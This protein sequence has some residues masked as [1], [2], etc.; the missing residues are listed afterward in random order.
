MA[1]NKRHFKMYARYDGTGK[2]IPGSNI[3]AKKAPKVG[4]WVEVQAYEC[5]NFTTTTTSTTGEPPCVTYQVFVS[6]GVALVIYT[7]CSGEI[8]SV[9]CFPGTTLFCALLGQYTVLGQAGVFLIAESCLV[10]TTTTTVEPVACSIPQE[11][12]SQEATYPTEIAIDLG[13]DVGEV[14]L[15]YDPIIVPDR[16]VVWWD[17][18]VVI[19]TGYVSTSTGMYNYG[20]TF[21]SSLTSALLGKVDPVTG[22]TYPFANPAHDVDN[23]PIVTQVT[24]GGAQNES[25]DKTDA[26]PTVALIRV[27][28]P[29]EGTAWALTMDCPITITTTTTQELQP[30]DVRLKE[31][32]KATGNK[33]GG[34]DEYTW[35]WN[36]KAKELGFDKYPTKGVL[37]LDVAVKRPDAVVLDKGYMKVNYNLIR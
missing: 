7:D 13:T 14:V 15:N 11:F 6:R 1:S 28:A 34:F 21:R 22:S 29:I 16:F 18:N 26:T 17:G 10:T 12:S 25:F 19:D 5:C 32:I 36:K 4:N 23:Y 2:I 8:Q 3:W 27:Y 33:V 30:S 24:G 37:A 35:Q 9:E 31:N 20:D